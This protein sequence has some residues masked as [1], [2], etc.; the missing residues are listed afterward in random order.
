MQHPTSQNIQFA[1]SLYDYCLR[2]KDKLQPETIAQAKRNLIMINQNYP[3]AAK[4]VE[5]S[6][7]TPNKLITNYNYGFMFEVPKV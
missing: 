6:V 3:I 1:Y 7:L 2:N 5:V 4:T